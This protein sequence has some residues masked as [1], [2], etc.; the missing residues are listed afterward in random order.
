[1][2]TE[3]YNLKAK[4]FSLTPDPDYFFLSSGH[5]RA[6]TYLNY[7]IREG[8]GFVVIS[9]EIGAG[10]TTLLRT[11][12]KGI[13]EDEVSI[14]FIRNTMVTGTQLVKII[15][16][17][18][19]IPDVWN[20]EKEQILSSMNYF[21]IDQFGRNKK[22]LLII[23]EA[24]NLS[25][26]TLEEIRLL[27]NLETDKHKLLQIILSGQPELRDKL[28]IPQLEQLR[29]RVILSYH[30]GPLSMEE[31]GEYIKHRMHRAGGDGIFKEE[32]FKEIYDF[33]GGTPRLINIICE[34]S[35]LF[36]FVEGRPAIDLE[37]VKS[38]REDLER[39][40]IQAVKA[41]YVKGL[42][43]AEPYDKAGRVADAE[44]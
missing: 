31:T 44:R 12:L 7:A 1:M 6:F 39:D 16:D 22:T 3:Y 42:H 38:V 27:S 17:D 13:K 35:L 21:L 18:F 43:P 2:Y 23:D 26:S 32:T 4:P 37:I 11:V 28:A 10:K 9:G 40:R 20:Q 14:S 36:G 41:S 34:F 19:G 15:A 30:L 8:E 5:R 25:P 29:Q 24:Q 33:S